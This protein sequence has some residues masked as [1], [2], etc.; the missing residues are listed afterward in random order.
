MNFSSEFFCY[1]FAL[2][3]SAT[4]QLFLSNFLLTF[5]L[6]F[7]A[8]IFISTFLL[9]FSTAFFFG[10]FWFKQNS[11]ADIFYVTFL[12]IDSAANKNIVLQTELFC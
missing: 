2:H 4:I 1:T 12:L 6:Y 5:L 9:N 7:S 3:F 8:E 10:I 11:F